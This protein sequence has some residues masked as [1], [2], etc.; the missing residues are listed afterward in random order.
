MHSLPGASTMEHC[1]LE[2]PRPRPVGLAGPLFRQ[3]HAGRCTS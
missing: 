1:K 3:P 2:D